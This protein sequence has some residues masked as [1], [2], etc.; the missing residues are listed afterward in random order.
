MSDKNKNSDFQ[1]SSNSAIAEVLRNR[2]LT[3]TI[4]IVL[5]LILVVLTIITVLAFAQ[6][7]KVSI[8]GLEQ[9]LFPPLLLL[10]A[11]VT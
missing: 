1:A 3:W 7:R 10:L 8:F 4:V 9:I 5:T 2:H 11:R 6:G